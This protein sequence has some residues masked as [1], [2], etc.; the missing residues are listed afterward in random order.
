MSLELN[1]MPAPAFDA[2]GFV[3][4][5]ISLIRELV[6]EAVAKGASDGVAQII[7]FVVSHLESQSLL[8]RCMNQSHVFGGLLTV[9]DAVARA[10]DLRDLPLG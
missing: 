6:A 1:P 7:T 4:A 2:T 9:E 10:C 8:A 3:D 5:P